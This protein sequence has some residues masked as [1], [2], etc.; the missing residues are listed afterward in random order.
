MRST[1]RVSKR[2]SL[3][4]HDSLQVPRSA[5]QNAKRRRKQNDPPKRL[6][7]GRRQDGPQTWPPC[8]RSISRACARGIQSCHQA[9]L[10]LTCPD[11]YAGVLICAYMSSARAR[12]LCAVSLS[13][14]ASPR[15]TQLLKS[16][17][18]RIA[19]LVPLPAN[20]Q[21]QLLCPP[22]RSTYAVPR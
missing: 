18:N 11:T 6:D 8:P 20:A 10:N 15:V 9:H 17:Y 4:T 1:A 12:E 22:V 7:C 14:F 13:P 19:K 21:C 2:L 16:T 5:P 3:N